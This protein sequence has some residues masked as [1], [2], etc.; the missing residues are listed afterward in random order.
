MRA[1]CV[2]TGLLLVGQAAILQ[3]ATVYTSRSDFDS[4]VG[5]TVTED[6][7]I[8]GVGAAILTDSLNAASSFPGIFGFSGVMPGQ[9]V[10]GVTFDSPGATN[11]ITGPQDA[12]FAIDIGGPAR[13][14]GS[15]LAAYN[16]GGP[17]EPIIA[18]FVPTVVAIGFDTDHIYTGDTFTASLFYTD[19][20]SETL[21]LTNSAPDGQLA[22]YGLVSDSGADIEG[23]SL[24]GTSAVDAGFAVGNFSFT[25]MEVVHS[26]SVPLPPAAWLAAAVVPLIIV[27]RRFVWSICRSA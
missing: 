19:G 18:T 23:I 8:G 17:P 21:D 1:L 27:A 25:S 15:F 20:S 16:H 2:L 11:P 6:F 9:I 3:G 12:E 24:V 7:D 13:F 4:A 22:F 14:P 10:P 26:S 5:P